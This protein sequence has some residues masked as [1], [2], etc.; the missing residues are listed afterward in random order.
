MV[1][2]WA[3]SLRRHIVLGGTGGILAKLSVKPLRVCMYACTDE[4]WVNH[5]KRSKEVAPYGLPFWQPNWF[6]VANYVPNQPHTLTC[7][8]LVAPLNGAG[9][10]SK[11]ELRRMTCDGHFS[12]LNKAVTRGQA[13]KGVG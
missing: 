13:M 1:W 10:P 12:T 7:R 4:W 2:V 9:A 5:R 8:N 11:F 3:T 6:P